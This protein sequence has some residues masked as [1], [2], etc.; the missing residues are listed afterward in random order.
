M[1]DDRSSIHPPEVHLGPE[2]GSGAPDEGGW[3]DIARRI[4]R[5]LRRDVARLV[6]AGDEDDWNGIRDALAARVKGQA[7]SIDTGEVG[8][9]VEDIGKQVEEQVR[10]GL[11]GASG[12]GR[13]ADWATI[14]RSLRERVERVLDPNK[15][16]YPGGSGTG[17]SAEDA[18]I[19]AAPP[20]PDRPP[21][22]AQAGG[23][24]TGLPTVTQD[25]DE[26]PAGPPG[27]MPARPTPP[28]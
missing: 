21:P 14:G 20:S 26:P 10:T 6:G 7:E 8:R 27:G 28:T 9:R 15:P 25:V 12:A 13:D 23:D 5:Q 3:A 22:P 17:A 16:P 19:P 18:S 4:E 2:L 11:A 1:Q 24:D